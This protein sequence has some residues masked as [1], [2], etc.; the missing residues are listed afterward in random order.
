MATTVR[1]SLSVMVF[2][3][4]SLTTIVLADDA[5]RNYEREYIARVIQLFEEGDKSAIADQICYPLMRHK[6]LPPVKNSQEMTERFDQ[7]FDASFIAGIIASDPELDWSSAGWR[8]WMLKHGS[9]WL[10]PG[11][12]N[13]CI[14]GVNHQTDVEKVLGQELIAEQK[15]KLH[16][17]L[18]SFESTILL[19]ETEKFRIRVD[20]LGDNVYRYASWPI[21]K[22]MSEKPSLVILKGERNFEGSGGNHFYDFKNGKYTYRCS[23]GVT[24]SDDSGTS[25]LLEVFKGSKMILSQDVI[26]VI[27]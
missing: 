26:K 6:P 18:K 10:W 4:A 13:A 22:P 7:V 25:H 17:S 15:K 3:L 27:Y 11:P 8:G 23:V 21:N 1:F 2:W 16:S 9:L 20:E 24:I 14:T 12:E 5:S 19:W